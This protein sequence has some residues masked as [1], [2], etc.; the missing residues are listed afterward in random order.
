[1]API[2][3]TSRARLWLQFFLGLLYL[4]VVAGLLS[5]AT[6]HPFV[7]VLVAVIGGA[8]SCSI[9]A[10][11]WLTLWAVR[12]DSRIGQYGIGS[13]LFLTVF[14]A[15]YFGL[16]R[17]TA[18]AIGQNPHVQVSREEVL[19]SVALMCLCA[20]IL[21]VP[22]V[23]GMTESLLWFAVWVLRR[24]PVQRLLR[25]RGERG[26]EAQTKPTRTHL[27]R[28]QLGSDH[29]GLHPTVAVSDQTTDSRKRYAAVWLLSLL[30]STTPT[31]GTRPTLRA[32]V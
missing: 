21:A 24:R 29:A 32:R 14:V 1:M 15:L 12:R 11:T 16:V 10:L 5:I 6:W 9:L 13:L 20:S 18:D 8:L 27:A 4:G 17:W 22:F 23:L 25:R 31:L 30:R 3:P 7:V 2:P 26:K 28:D 19:T